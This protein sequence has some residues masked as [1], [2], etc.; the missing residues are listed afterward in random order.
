MEKVNTENLYNDS[1][2]TVLYCKNCLS[3]RIM[4]I[5]DIENSDFSKESLKT[6]Y[7]D[8]KDILNNITKL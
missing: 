7:D 2:N 5:E 3:L 4:N 1:N 8:I 6:L